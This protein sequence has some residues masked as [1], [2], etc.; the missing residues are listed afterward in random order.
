MGN[1][2]SIVIIGQL[3]FYSKGFRCS[4]PER[5]LRAYSKHRTGCSGWSARRRTMH[6]EGRVAQN[7][8]Y[9]LRGMQVERYP[10]RAAPI[11]FTIF[12]NAVL[13]G[14]RVP[15]RRT[16]VAG[17][18]TSRCFRGRGQPR[19]AVRGAMV[20]E[21][22][23]AYVFQMLRTLPSPCAAHRTPIPRNHGLEGLQ[24][25]ARSFDG[26]KWLCYAGWAVIPV[27]CLLLPVQG[28]WD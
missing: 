12:R 13:R 19:K 15:H 22:Q 11:V 17:C 25:T 18:R 8:R 23:N 27:A 7:A 14:H 5:N 21:P 20:C 2:R 10:Q 28:G 26:T 9:V 24:H 3:Y 16:A 1:R 4:N 6:G